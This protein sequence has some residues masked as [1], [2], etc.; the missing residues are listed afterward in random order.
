MPNIMSS[1]FFAYL[2]QKLSNESILLA[3]V[4]LAATALS[5]VY[6]VGYLTFFGVPADVIEISIFRIISSTFAVGLVASCVWL[7]LSKVIAIFSTDYGPAKR[8]AEWV[9]WLLVF[10]LLAWWALKVHWVVLAG[11]LIF[12]CLLLTIRGLQILFGRIGEK[13]ANIA[14]AIR[15]GEE[16][17]RRADQLAFPVIIPF[18]LLFFVFLLT[19]IVGFNYAK[20]NGTQWVLAENQQFVL[21]RRYG[22]V[23]IFKE[24]DNKSGVLSGAVHLMKVGDSSALKLVY[25]EGNRL[26][27]KKSL[28]PESK[29]PSHE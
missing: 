4:P 12:P 8:V 10:L 28:E 29:F 11:S 25:R 22:D 20:L 7:V 19:A 21:V 26:T 17:A 2:K 1:N 27:S 5:Y 24:F 6:E 16:A 23:Y 18:L 9:L 3:L 14:D 15:G 13:N